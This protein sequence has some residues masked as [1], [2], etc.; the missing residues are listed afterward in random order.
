MTTEELKEACNRIPELNTL[1]NA[2]V[3]IALNT[4][5]R[6]LPLALR[7]H[8]GEGL[9]D[10]EHSAYHVQQEEFDAAAQTLIRACAKHGIT[11]P[12]LRVGEICA[13]YS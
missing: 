4:Q 1:W 11:P 3:D 2:L 8:R 13:L 6:G 5:T 12:V 9:S 7:A 10:E